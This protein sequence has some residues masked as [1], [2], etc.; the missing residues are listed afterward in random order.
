M[1]RRDRKY[2]RDVGLVIHRVLPSQIDGFTQA[3]EQSGRDG[4]QRTLVIIC[5]GIRYKA[6]SKQANNTTTAAT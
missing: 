4:R 5:K 1:V 2:E 3:S 6:D